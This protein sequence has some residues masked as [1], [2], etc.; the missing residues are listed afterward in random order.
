MRILSGQVHAAL[1]YVTVVIFAL[2][3]S[4]V[5]LSGA[6]AII[7]Y[8]L[9]VVHL[10]M[11]LVTDIPFSLLKVMPLKLHALV[12]AIVGPVLVIGGLFL[13]FSSQARIFFI[14]MG[15]SS[16]LTGCSRAT[17]LRA[18]RERCPSRSWPMSVGT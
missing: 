13:P 8:A 18:S 7:S 12:E 2:G 15:R 5:G 9:A 14:V 10:A 3:P 1:D 4:I 6:A 16:W 17:A 11:T